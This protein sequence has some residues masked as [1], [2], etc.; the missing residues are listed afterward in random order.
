MTKAAA[1]TMSNKKTSISA[2]PSMTQLTELLMSEES[3]K[4]KSNTILEVQS[5]D[6]DPNPSSRTFPLHSLSQFLFNL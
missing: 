1:P 2:P 3:K 5:C 6:F 4:L